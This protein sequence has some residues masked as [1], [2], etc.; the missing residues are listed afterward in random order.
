[1][2]ALADNKGAAYTGRLSDDG[3]LDEF[4][5]SLATL[6]VSF[7]TCLVSLAFFSTSAS[8]TLISSATCFSSSAMRR[9]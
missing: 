8:L 6:S 9:I 4:F 1:M 3:G 2:I 7:V 5:E